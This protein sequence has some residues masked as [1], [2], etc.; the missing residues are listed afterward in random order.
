M[1]RSPSRD[2]LGALVRVV[3]LCAVAALARAAAAQPSDSTAPAASVASPTV[4]AVGADLALQALAYLGVPYRYGGEDPQRGFDCSGLVRHVTRSVLQVEVGDLV[5]FNTR[6]RRNSH[7]GFYLGEGRFVHAPARNGQVR[8]ESI[9][10]AYW[11][12][13]YNGARR[14]HIDAAAA[15]RAGDPA[16]TAVEAPANE[17]PRRAP[18]DDVPG[19]HPAGGA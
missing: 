3:A 17:T 12:Q 16:T 18:A 5:F 8:I 14:L 11:R 7:V 15:G 9:G 19:P 2:W 4:V 6:G 13:R 10:D 1:T